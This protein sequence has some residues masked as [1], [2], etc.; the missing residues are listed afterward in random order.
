M[1]TKRSKILSVAFFLAAATLTQGALAAPECERPEADYGINY[2]FVSGEFETDP[3][4]TRWIHFLSRPVV[5]RVDPSGPAA[6]RLFVGDIFVSVEGRLITSPA[7]SRRFRYP[8]QSPVEVVVQRD[9]NEVSLQ[10]EPKLECP[11]LVPQEADAGS[12]PE[13]PKGM[14][15]VRF[16]CDQC[17]L[18]VVGGRWAWHFESPPVVVEVA[19]GSPASAADV[20]VGDRLRSLDGWRLDTPEGAQRFSGVAP[21][22]TV[23]LVLDRAGQEVE[24]QLVAREQP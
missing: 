1:M 18:R 2:R 19:E 14:L 16:R 7:G 3:D 21:G 20:Q 13:G 24:V 6:R 12:V 5:K 8:E 4:G 23:R 17:E 10:I 11:E 15:G 9:G 22:E